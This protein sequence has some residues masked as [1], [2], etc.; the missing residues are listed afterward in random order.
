MKSTSLAA[1]VEM[2]RWPSFAVAL[3]VARL[4][5]APAALHGAFI[6][7]ALYFPTPRPP[8]RG[9]SHGCAQPKIGTRGK[10]RL[11][12]ARLRHIARCGPLTATS[13]WCGFCA[14]NAPTP[15]RGPGD[16]ECLSFP[17][18]VRF[19]AP[20]RCRRPGWRAWPWRALRQRPRELAVT[21]VAGTSAAEVSSAAISFTPHALEHG[22]RRPRC[23]TCWAIPPSPS[24]SI[25]RPPRDGRDP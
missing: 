24:R 7:G 10:T 8:Y 16:V 6:D 9:T 13:T 19:C 18:G 11:R 15:H 12:P 22:P 23:P 5:I 4:E 20:R 14:S 1:R 21:F 17:S 3:L 25:S 2:G